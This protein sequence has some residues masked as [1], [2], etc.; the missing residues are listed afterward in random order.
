[1]ATIRCGTVIFPDIQAVLFDKDGTLANSEEF[2]RNLGQRRSRLIDAQIPGVQEPL[3]M[4]F[5]IDDNQVNPAGLLA[6]GTRRENEIAAAAYVAE[7]GRGWVEALSIVHSVFSDADRYLGR[8]AEQ[9]PLF[10]ESIPLL[11]TLAAAGLKLGIVSSDTSTNVEDFVAVHQLMPYL[12]AQTGIDD[13]PGKPDPDCVY[14][15]CQALEVTPEKTL[16]IGDSQADIQLARAA[17]LAGCIGVTWG[18]SQPLT[19]ISGA[20]VSIAEF[21]DIQLEQ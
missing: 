20:D 10:S 3:L 21:S 11:K 1:M 9:T 13:G 18:W 17:N 7:T 8:K 16:I 14:R 6:V 4:A 5:G 2:L 19:T 15:S 12:Q